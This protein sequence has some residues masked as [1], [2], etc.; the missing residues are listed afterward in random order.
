MNSDISASIQKSRK[1]LYSPLYIDKENT[2]FL[3]GVNQIDI[4]SFIQVNE[5]YDFLKK[6]VMFVK[7][8]F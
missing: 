3:L 2:T 1:N 6:L 7:S 5:L 8:A 4:L